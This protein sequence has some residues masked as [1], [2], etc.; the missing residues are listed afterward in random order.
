MKKHG[1]IVYDIFVQEKCQQYW[2]NDAG[3]IGPFHIIIQKEEVLD[4]FAIRKFIVRK[5]MYQS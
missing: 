2:P 1:H 4:Q 5:V 3:E